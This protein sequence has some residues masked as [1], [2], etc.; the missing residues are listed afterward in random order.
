[1]HIKFV[2]YLLPFSSETCIFPL[3]VYINK[4]QNMQHYNC[5]RFEISTTL[6]IARLQ[7]VGDRWTLMQW[8]WQGETESLSENLS[9]CHFVHKYNNSGRAFATTSGLNY[10]TARICSI[11]LLDLLSHIKRRTQAQDFFRKGVENSG[12]TFL[13]SQPPPFKELT[14]IRPPLSYVT[15]TV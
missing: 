15:T 13:F 8:Q 1:M 3:A 7:S 2:E 6:S 4:D 5:A 12:E 10:F 9:L 11:S 14:V